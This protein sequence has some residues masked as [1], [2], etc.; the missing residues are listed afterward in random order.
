LVQEYYFV[1]IFLVH[2]G[3]RNKNQPR[4]PQPSTSYKPKA[5][6]PEPGSMKRKTINRGNPVENVQIT[7]II[8]TSEPADFHIIEKLN[9]ENLETAPI[10][11]SKSDRARLQRSGKVTSTCSCD[12]VEIAKPK[13]VNLKGK[14]IH[15]QHA[16]GIG[17][18]NDTSGKL[19][20][21]YYKSEIRKLFP[22][23]KRKMKEKVEYMTFR[24]ETGRNTTYISGTSKLNINN[25][26]YNSNN[27]INN[28]Y[29]N[30][31]NYIRSYNNYNTNNNPNFNNKIEIIK[32]TETKIEMGNRSQH[33]IGV[34]NRGYINNERRIYNPN[35]I[36]KKN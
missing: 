20:P 35:Y 24:N 18:T 10:Q 17:M 4:R 8:F 15:Y 33:M 6:S 32:E 19:N 5:R 2:K 3:L 9:L 34:N 28:S 25:N 27:N 7:H 14:T 23:V 12:G 13:K 36:Y 21:L 30:S 16:R 26:N 11:I 31:T 1:E 22:Y 29:R